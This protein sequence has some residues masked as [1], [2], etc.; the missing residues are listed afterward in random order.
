MNRTVLQARAIGMGRGLAGAGVLATALLG[1]SASNALAVPAFAVQTG[2]P[3][4]AC[5][6]GGFGPQLTPF[7]RDF[8]MH[9]Y[10]T[11]TV[12]FNVPISAMAVASYLHT[13][14]DQNPPA[15]DFAP[16]DNW[17]VDQVSLF[18]AGGVG[19]HFGG[20][21]QA[22]YDGVAR[23]YHWD[24]LDVR[25]VT[26]TSLGSNDVLLGV[27][28]NNSPTVQ[29]PWNTLGAWGFPYTTSALA[30]APAASPI[31]G[32]FAQTSMGTT[33]YALLN[34]EIYAEV[35]AYWSPGAG[36]LTHAGVDPTDPGPINGAA[37][38]ARIA[39]QKSYA[40]QNFQV[41]A[42]VMAASLFPGDDHSTGMTDRYTDL[43]F[44]AS[45]QRSL[46]QKS[47]WTVNMRYTHED[48]RLRASQALGATQ[49]VSNS[50]E[51]FRLDTSYYWK[52]KVGGTVS[53]FDTWG[54]AD[55]LLYAGSRTLKPDSSGLLF[56]I[57]GTPFGDGKS[58]FG[59]RFNV[60]VGIQ[61]TL[62][63]E[64]NGAATNYDGFGHNASDNNS[65]RVF[66]W[67]AY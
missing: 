41:G 66:T 24:N 62:Y 18:L 55:P 54:S 48:Q 31:I 40:D 30:P 56:Q 14:Q 67:L 23:A 17:A 39:Y 15:P 8:K 28:V 27:S 36:F 21:V 13:S 45:Y 47:T 11:R 1:L 64:F 53:F 22:T 35:G 38:Y 26:T 20:F 65:V 32:A 7:G 50:L 5:H 46:P 9:G 61:Y 29:D 42:F 3:C 2:Q 51:D 37:P 19:S 44:D 49:F 4:E 59:P 52:G 58:P 57:D 25:A 43:G 10:T 33:A 6:V 63:T 34:K 16:N 60:R 12:S